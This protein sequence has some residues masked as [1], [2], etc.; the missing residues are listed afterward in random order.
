VKVHGFR[1]EPAEIETALAAAPGVRRC[2]V[3]AVADSRCGKRLVAYVKS[4]GTKLDELTLQAHLATWLPSYMVP[5]VYVQLSAIPLLPS[6][7][8]DRRALPTPVSGD[9]EQHGFVAPRTSMESELAAIWADVLGRP[10]IGADDNFFA[11]G[12]DSIKRHRILGR[13]SRERPIRV[14]A[15]H[16]LLLTVFVDDDDG[17][18][19]LR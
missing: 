18:P 10:Q 6:G 8:I 5:S 1:V 19:I 13:V 17:V 9:T 12:G 11:L 2:A 16:R 7:K 14:N 4:D 15:G 3:A